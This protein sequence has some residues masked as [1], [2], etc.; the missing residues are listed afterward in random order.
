MYVT[1]DGRRIYYPNNVLSQKAINNIRRS[2]NMIDKI[3]V[4]IDVYTPQE[5]IFDLR[6]RMRDF[7]ARE[8]KEFSPEMEIQIQEIDVRL[9]ISMCIEYKSNGRILA[10]AGHVIP[11]STTH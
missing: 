1:W 8:I 7:L 2:P 10:D 11:S 9:K 6:S 3:V 5:K 4:H